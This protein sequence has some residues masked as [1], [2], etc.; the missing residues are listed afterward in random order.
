[1]PPGDSHGSE[2]L[3]VPRTSSCPLPIN[4]ARAPGKS[5]SAFKYPER[6]HSL[7][8]SSSWT[9][10]LEG[11]QKSQELSCLLRMLFNQLYILFRDFLRLAFVLADRFVY[12][13]CR[14]VVQQLRPHAQTPKGCR[15]NHIDGSLVKAR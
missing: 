10:C 12:R 1:P 3:P 14:T 9:P 6:T 4:T 13:Q 5:S 15:P 8:S 7:Q 2:N 11:V